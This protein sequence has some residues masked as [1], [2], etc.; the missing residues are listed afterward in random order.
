LGCA[1]L[2]A[3]QLTG[4]YV[5][6]PDGGNMSDGG[7]RRSEGTVEVVQALRKAGW[8]RIHAMVGGCPARYG[9]TNGS[10]DVYRYYVHS[11][12]FV[13]AVVSEVARMNYQGINIDFEPSDCLKKPEV[14]CS[15]ADCRAMGDMLS[16]IKAGV[17]PA[18]MV[19]V[20][21]GQS[22]LASTSCLNTSNADR[23]ISMNT[24]YNRKSFDISLP[25][26][27]AAVG[28]RRYGLGVCPTCS[29]PVCKAPA[30]ASNAADIAERM[31][32]AEKA[33]VV[34]IDFWASA[35]QPSWAY[36]QQWWAAIRKW[37]AAAAVQ[38]GSVGSFL[39]L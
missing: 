12:A 39:N 38:P 20:D 11:P 4:Y 1:R 34:H 22:A 7:L 24:Y 14:P 23:L 16:R 27:V 15:V 33:G 29:T 6:D 2:H 26:D 8:S 18:V 13:Q 19:S 3:S 25:R 36:G 31:A 10:I 37:K 21:T 32:L 17:G 28:V 5:A 9:G 30:C 35:Q